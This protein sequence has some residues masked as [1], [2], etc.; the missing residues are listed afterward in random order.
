VHSL[1]NVPIHQLKNL[2]LC[3]TVS[4]S[5]VDDGGS[6]SRVIL[7]IVLHLYYCGGSCF[8]SAI[9]EDETDVRIAI[10]ECEWI[11]APSGP[12]EA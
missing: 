3:G 8:V 5:R 7:P 10:V 11:V 6:Q 2:G 4:H 12:V 9:L 1:G